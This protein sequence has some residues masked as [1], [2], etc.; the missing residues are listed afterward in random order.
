MSEAPNLTAHDGEKLYTLRKLKNKDAWTGARIVAKVMSDPRFAMNAAQIASNPNLEE[1]ELNTAL[2]FSA[3]SSLMEHAPDD[4]E[5]FLMDLVGMKRP[6]WDDLPAEATFDVL[7]ELVERDDFLPI[8]RSATK[9][10]GVAKKAFS[11]WQ[12]RSN[13]NGDGPTESS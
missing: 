11:N 12:N 2:M 9:L 13:S 1:G 6:Q 5:A 3:I 10:S 7:S 4:V 8:A